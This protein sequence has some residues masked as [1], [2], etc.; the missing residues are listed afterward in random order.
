[1]DLLE[2]LSQGD[3]E[4]RPKAPVRRLIGLH[5]V[6]VSPTPESNMCL[7]GHQTGGCMVRFLKADMARLVFY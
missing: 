3:A 5:Q 2:Q 6:N 7:A 1:L 4:S